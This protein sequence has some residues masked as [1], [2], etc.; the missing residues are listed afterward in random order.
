MKTNLKLSEQVALLERQRNE[1]MFMVNRIISSLRR[2]QEAGF[3]T[4]IEAEYK[5]D[6]AVIL[7]CWEDELKRIQG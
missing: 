2:D 4:K 3:F 7:D 5:I 1:L 6:F